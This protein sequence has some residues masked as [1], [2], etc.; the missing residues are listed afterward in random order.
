MKVPIEGDGHEQHVSHDETE[1]K[2]RREE[3]LQSKWRSPMHQDV[4]SR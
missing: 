3:C 4:E 2:Q 1:C